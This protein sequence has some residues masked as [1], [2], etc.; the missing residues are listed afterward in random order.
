MKKIYSRPESLKKVHTHFCPGCGHGI[1]HKLICEV[2]DELKIREKMIAVAPVG[3]A[4]FGYNYWDF[5]TSEA[6]HGR[7]PAVATGIK[8]VHGISGR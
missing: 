8:R 5:D 2:V 4:V 6:A 1:I 7:T 3:C